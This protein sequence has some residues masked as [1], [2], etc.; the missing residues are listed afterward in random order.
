VE[1]NQD[2]RSVLEDQ[3]LAALTGKEMS[4]A[5]SAGQRN[6]RID[7]LLS[8]VGVEE[9]TLDGLLK[10]L[11]SAA[12]RSNRIESWLAGHDDAWVQMLYL[13]LNSIK[14][15]QA[16]RLSYLPIVRTAEGEHLR[17]RQAR[18]ILASIQR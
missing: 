10:Q 7:R 6:S 9:L 2:L 5:V 11:E 8:H 12:Q 1:G 17:A 18:P 15:Y 13:L 14:G 16:T 3:D 4:W